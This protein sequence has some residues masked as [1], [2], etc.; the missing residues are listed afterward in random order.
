MRVI[1]LCDPKKNK[2]CPKN[3]CGKKDGC[4]ATTHKEFAKQDSKGNVIL[5]ATFDARGYIC[6]VPQNQHFLK[7]VSKKERRWKQC[8]LRFQLALRLIFRQLFLLL[9]LSFPKC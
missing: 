1:Y 7:E 3:L 4:N 8:L 9:I 5:L 6:Y 2:Y